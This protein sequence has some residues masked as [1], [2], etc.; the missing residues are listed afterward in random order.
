MTKEVSVVVVVTYSILSYK[1]Y[2]V[3]LPEPPKEIEIVSQVSLPG[4][5][6]NV[7]L[8]GWHPTKPI[9]FTA[10]TDRRAYLWDFGQGLDRHKKTELELNI[11]DSA[12]CFHWMEVGKKKST[13]AIGKRK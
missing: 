3:F 2:I 13:L 5:T 11:S 6:Q 12:T 10:A 7:D 4:H 1:K 9:L 8:C